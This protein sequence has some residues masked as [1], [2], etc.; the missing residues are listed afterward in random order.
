MARPSPPEHVLDR[1]TPP[2][3]H[4]S[5]ESDASAVLSEASSNYGCAPSA[6][7]LDYTP[8]S[9]ACSDSELPTRRNCLREHP[10]AQLLRASRE[11]AKFMLA[12]IH[13]QLKAEGLI[14]ARPTEPTLLERGFQPDKR[15][16]EFIKCLCVLGGP[17]S[18]EITDGGMS[19]SP[20]KNMDG[21]RRLTDV[22]GYS[23]KL[24]HELAAPALPHLVTV[25]IP[26]PTTEQLI[27]LGYFDEPTE[28][29]SRQLVPDLALL[30]G[31][32]FRMPRPCRPSFSHP[33]TS[34]GDDTSQQ[35]FR[36]P[37]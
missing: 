34:T 13:T 14:L 11:A 2:S 27:L 26:T 31:M 8:P 25:K 36:R 22:L 33:L 24:I 6:R 32:R 3:Y 4:S 30:L 15:E 21:H 23:L 1:Y 28:D 12:H 16:R 19:T 35:S 17:H 5:E 18:S 20:L 29:Y 7:R 9:S 37:T 10:T